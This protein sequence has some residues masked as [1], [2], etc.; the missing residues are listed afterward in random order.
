MVINSTLSTPSFSGATAGAKAH[1][2]HKNSHA[3][4]T[5]T[6]QPDADADSSSDTQSVSAEN[7]VAATPI[8]N[9]AEALKTLQSVR[10]A[11][12]QQP[13]QA[14]QAQ[15]NLDPQTVYN[16]LAA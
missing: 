9:M 3:N 1:H 11:M 6:V 13:S 10:N 5:A 2:A 14:M 7:Q 16:L 8:S 15:A 12:M 4:N